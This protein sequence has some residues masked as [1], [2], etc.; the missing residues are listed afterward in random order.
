MKRISSLAISLIIASV[1]LGITIRETVLTF[2][3]KKIDANGILTYVANTGSMDRNYNDFTAGFEWP[4]G[5]GNHA[6]YASGLWIAAKINDSIRVGTSDYSSDFRPGYFDFATQTPVGENDPLYRLYKVSP[7]LPNGNTEFD[8]WSLWPVNQGAPWVDVNGNGTYD[9]PVDRPVMK[10]SQNLFCSFTDGYRDTVPS[11]RDTRP[12]RAEVK[13]F[14][15]ARHDQP[16]ADAI[17]YEWTIINKSVWQWTE[18][19]SAI[20]SDIDIGYALDDRG[21]SDSALG[22]VFGYNGTNNDP[23]YGVAPPA[24]GHAVRFA[25][26]HNQNRADFAQRWRC[27]FENCPIDSLHIYRVLHGLRTTGERYI[28]PLTNQ[29]TNFTHSGDAANQ[30]GWIDST[31]GD[32]YLLIGSI[33]GN[34][35][36]LD[37]VRFHTT[38]FIKRGANNF[39]AVTELKN[40]V[41]SVIS[42][43]NSLQTTPGNFSLHQNFPNPFNPETRIAYSLAKNAYIEIRVFDITGKIV[44]ELVNST[45]GPGEYKVNFSGAS[46]PAG[47]YC[48]TLFADGKNTGSRKMV[49]LK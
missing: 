16:C 45:Q 41:N 15:Y 30:T 21:G 29:P 22:I 20:F 34:V 37:T 8:N 1:L 23:V 49:L 32:K 4:K 10:G 48:Y 11:L 3:F 18:F 24:L 27:G 7:D 33:F 12:L 44:A 19:S 46:L 6:V 43:N 14:A 39:A 26:G 17:N 38:V 47:S 9:P 36:S 5:T 42:V 28:N 25:G 2:S 40:C 35:A 13:M 31:G